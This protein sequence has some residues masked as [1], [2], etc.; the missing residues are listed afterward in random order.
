VTVNYINN[1]MF[2]MSQE[3]NADKYAFKYVTAAGFNPGGPAS[4]MAKLRSEVGDLWVEG[5]ART[6]NPNN[7]PKT[8][9]R[10][11]KFGKQLYEYSDKHVKVEEEKTVKVNGV[12]II[13]PVATQTYLT[14]QRAYQIA[15]NIARLYANEA[16]PTTSASV[17][18]N[19]VYVGSQFIMTSQSGDITADAVASALN[20]AFAK[21]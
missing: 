18:G 17:Q 15:G 14:E 19:S 9:D 11:E 3:K 20:K 2:T 16:R 4:A 10:I 13:T 6:I 12:E 8:T 21:D 1:E 5:L 7:H